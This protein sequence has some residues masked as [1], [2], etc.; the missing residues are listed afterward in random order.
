MS[1][2][3]S[4][5]LL[6][7]IIILFF[8]GLIIAAIIYVCKKYINLNSLGEQIG[9]W[10]A[11]MLL[12][13]MLFKMYR[14]GTQ[15]ATLKQLPTHQFLSELIK[16]KGKA[17]S[18]LFTHKETS[19]SKKAD[20]ITPVFGDLP[21]AM[22]HQYGRF[23]S[24]KVRIL[25]LTGSASDV[26]LLTPGLTV[27]HWQ[28]DAG[29]VLVWGGDLGELLDSH[30]MSELR[31]LRRRPLD[32][33]IWVTSALSHYSALGQK[34]SKTTLSA[35]MMDR[36][37]QA[38]SSR[39][40]LL[41]WRLPLFVWSLCKGETET[42][43]RSFQSVG[44]SLPVGCKPDELRLQ[45]S[46]LIP[47][48]IEKG[49]LRV[50][51][52]TTQ[53]FLLQ[54][55][56]RLSR[57]LDSVA[58]P[59]DALLNPY[60]PTPLAGIMFSPASTEAKRT[61]KYHW[62]KDSRWDFLLSSLSSLPT[63]LAAKKIGFS[64]RRATA[65]VLAAVMMLWGA[66]LI[67]SFI[68]NRSLVSEAVS[69]S[70]QASNTHKSTQSRL[71][72]LLDLQQLTEKLQ[73]R[74]LNG[75][76]WY[77]R[78]GLNQNDPLL[79]AM[80]PQYANSALP[81][82]RDAA[83][84][85]LQEKLD[86]M[87]ALPPDSSQRSALIK[88]TYNQ[89]RLYLMLARPDKMDAAWFTPELLKTWPQREGVKNGFWQGSGVDLIKYYATAL[90]RHPKWALLADNDLVNDVRA[91]L[92]RQIGVRNGE[93]SLYQKMMSQVS[94]QY[95]D[96]RLQDMVGDTDSSMLF[97]TEEV[98]PGMFT[99]Q[100]W[101]GAVKSA[102]EKVA[103][104]RR[105]EVDWVLSDNKDTVTAALSPEELKARLTARY[106][107]DF[108]GSWL[109]FL[110]SLRWQDAATLSDAV[111]QLTLM[112]DVRQSP[113]VA[114]MNTLSVQGRTGQ[115]GEG[116]SD[117]LVKSA[118]NLFNS[119]SQP[120][121]DQ[122]KGLHGP[123]DP[124]FGPL[125]ALLDGTAG[126]QGDTSLSLQTFLTRVTQVRL[127][128]Q[129]VINASDPQA[130]TQTLAQTVFQGKAID[131]TETRDYGSLVAA[132][133]G[134]EWS[135]FG[136]TLF[137]RPMEQAW[138]Q[139]LTPAAESLNTQWQSAIVN[140]WNSAFGGRYPLKSSSSEIS[141]PLLAQYLNGDSGR[142]SRFLQT[143]LSGVLHKEGSHWVPDSINAQ[144]LEFNPAFIRAVDTLS[145]ISDVVFTTGPA[146]LSFEI[147]PGTA[148]GVM[149][150]NLIIDNQKLVYVNQM[151]VWKRFTWPADT[152]APGA[153]LSWISTQAGT[154]QLA[155]IPGAWGWIRLLDLA[156]IAPYQGLNSSWQ[157]TWKA[158]D[159]YALN[160]VLRTEAGEG[161]LA[162]LK[163]RN[164]V[165]PD[166]IFVTS[167]GTTIAPDA[168]ATLSDSDLN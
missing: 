39:N 56:D 77:S 132:S 90:P 35:D 75:T 87:T 149:Q 37:A 8:V 5:R 58:G 16:S 49:T 22:K 19:T 156:A 9:A 144:G 72:A 41:R 17:I 153:A 168:T 21:A 30:W 14:V 136:R 135:G 108:S 112:A 27:Q 92:V 163:L 3:R 79:R 138:Q 114:L 130:M 76:P 116:L 46:S 150:T 161:P 154:R 141:L 102:I 122:G 62:G 81:L 109:D 105:E 47:A 133:L 33:I 97:S 2:S 45:L 148:E 38:F 107:S 99:R 96:L 151:P 155:D 57:K 53:Q 160:Y 162:L 127:K 74:Q 140:D 11:S 54:L 48:L 121:I 68:A 126:G 88:P 50:S 28:E 93:A 26:E 23:W 6:G 42:V 125:L 34:D 89:L 71:Q 117:S 167:G 73:F 164:F 63:G 146:G 142:I 95:A 1:T 60:R 64:W 143:R 66:G 106:F 159:G 98:V 103:N 91:I 82:I 152:E 83:A 4:L 137:V 119:N 124:S 165:L 115:T 12:L 86:A 61:V 147:R 7:Q 18:S 101:E 134:Q 32:G 84:N 80:W 100:A 70:E 129:Q 10:C 158:K 111:D 85:A 55:A 13:M 51:Q 120:A 128:L 43:E 145:H 65:I 157:L 40:E 67:A 31:Q 29:T 24:R 15:Y 110:N 69:L 52:N 113:L 118:Q 25:L 139:V 94:H 59:L 36:L 123:L 78:F 166:T 104:E 44:C 20:T 131:L